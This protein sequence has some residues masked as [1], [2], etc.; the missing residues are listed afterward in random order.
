MAF[1]KF[2]NLRALYKVFR[3]VYLV[4]LLRSDFI[5]IGS[6]YNIIKLHTSENNI[7]TMDCPQ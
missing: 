3:V 7:Y 4:S 2:I 6:I 1:L 5:S